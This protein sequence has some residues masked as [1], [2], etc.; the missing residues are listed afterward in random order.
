MTFDE[1]H[2]NFFP[3]GARGIGETSFRIPM[4]K[5]ISFRADVSYQS[6]L[7]FSLYFSLKILSL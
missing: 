6:L 7:Y 1:S 5:V 4:D 3:E 2:L